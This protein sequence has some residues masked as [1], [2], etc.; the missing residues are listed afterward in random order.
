M[1]EICNYNIIYC[2][3]FHHLYNVENIKNRKTK[4]QTSEPIEKVILIKN[5]K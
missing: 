1:P 2:N 5:K 3:S 4:W